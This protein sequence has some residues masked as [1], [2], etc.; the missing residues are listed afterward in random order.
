MDSWIHEIQLRMLSVVPKL[1]SEYVTME[2]IYPSIATRLAYINVSIGFIPLNVRLGYKII[3]K[4]LICLY[5]FYYFKSYTLTNRDWPQYVLLRILRH[6]SVHT[7]INI[8]LTSRTLVRY[9]AINYLHTDCFIFI[10][11]I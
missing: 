1:Y 2:L 4:Y 11:S 7:Y 10:Y 5:L 3:N 8:R 9:Y 6:R